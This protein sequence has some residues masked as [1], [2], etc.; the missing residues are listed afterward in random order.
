MATLFLAILPD[1]PARVAIQ[2]AALALRERHGLQGRAVPADRYHLTLHFLGN[3]A[4]PLQLEG[5]ARAA[6]RAVTEALATR[7]AVAATAF[8]DH[9]RSFS[10]IR[11]GLH[12]VVLCATA[13]S[14]GDGLRL[15]WSDVAAALAAARLLPAQPEAF[16]PHVTVGRD[17]SD[18]PL[19]RIAPIRWHA[20]SLILLRGVPGHPG[21]E[22]LAE[23]PLP[24]DA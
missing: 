13:A 10:R 22:T 6:T 3:A 1:A 20:A 14:P 24:R 9:A 2:A 8:L 5:Q 7:D 19:Q 21:Y 16:V 15:L 11:P 4:T 17:R 12:P 23:W 18:V